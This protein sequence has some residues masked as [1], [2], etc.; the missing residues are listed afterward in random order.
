MS[1]VI[2]DLAM[3]LDGYVAGVHDE[4]DW[5]ADFDPNDYGFPEFIKT[6]GAI[7][8]GKRSY[9]IGIE[10]GWF[11]NNAY[12]TSPIFVVSKDIPKIVSDDARF[13]FVSDIQSAY[14][15]AQATAGNKNIY[16]FGGASIFQQFLNAGLIDEIHI[17]IVATILGK[18]IRLFD[19]LADKRV[20]LERTKVVEY[21]KGLTGINY[22]IIK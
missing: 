10:Q 15:K 2:L 3:S 21:P 12:G 16:L 6:V 22:R 19:N 4:I 1:K 7:V 5:L 18:G 11:K 20:R 17:G 14:E 9:D 8:M 13:Y